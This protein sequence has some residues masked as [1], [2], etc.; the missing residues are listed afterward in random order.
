MRRVIRALST[1]L[2]PSQYTVRRRKASAALSPMRVAA[3]G[4][5]RARASRGGGGGAGGS[6]GAGGGGSAE[7]SPHKR[8]G[9]CAA[10]LAATKS[11]ATLA[12][13]ADVCDM[14]MQE[15][16]R[17]EAR[18]SA[19]RE[20]EAERTARRESRLSRR[21]SFDRV[22]RDSAEALDAGEAPVI[23]APPVDALAADATG[24][25]PAPCDHEL[26]DGGTARESAPPGT[27][28]SAAA[29]RLMGNAPVGSP[30]AGAA[31]DPG[32]S[33]TAWGRGAFPSPMRAG[34]SPMGCTDAPMSSPGSGMSA[35][36]AAMLR[37][38]R[39][40]VE[41]DNAE[42]NAEGGRPGGV[43]RVRGVARYKDC[44]VVR[45]CDFGCSREVGG[46]APAPS[47]LTRG[48]SAAAS[49]AVPTLARS[50]SL[51]SASF[52]TFTSADPA[53]VL[54]SLDDELS[55]CNLSAQCSWL[56]S[57]MAMGQGFECGPSLFDEEK[58]AP[59]ALQRARATNPNR[60]RLS[61]KVR[62]SSHP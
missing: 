1:L 39:Q 19:E 51:S 57:A 3:A 52:S 48:A 62:M 50:S 15:R 30:L 33:P 53:S 21:M 55:A 17:R 20:R 12:A 18:R 36:D 49:G 2:P 27:P 40:R 37:A 10:I 11:A 46:S 14:R 25:E 38:R 44:G 5:A 26:S 8:R 42:C 54:P 31:D 6:P 32:A 16:A 9:S 22:R 41:G 43:A 56:Q 34:A 61:V 7:L 29:R 60:H 58:E 47:V 24:T 13:A 23:A 59:R 28:P 35:R 4:V 45:S